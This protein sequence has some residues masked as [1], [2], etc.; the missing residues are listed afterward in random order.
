MFLFF[1]FGMFHGLLEGLEIGSNIKKVYES[2]LCTGCGTCMSICPKSAVEI[3]KDDYEGTYIPQVKTETCD[4]CGLC[5]RVC[6][7]Y[8]VDFRELNLKMFGKQP[9]NILIG[10]YIAC[11]IGHATD[12]EMRYNSASGGL[13]T[14][15]LIFALE[16]GIIDGALVTRMSQHKP[17]E[18]EV[19]I[20]RSKEEI[21]SASGSKYCPVPVNIGLKKILNEK[22]KFAIVGLP[23]HMHGVRKLEMINK[24][25]QD[26]IALHLGLFCSNSVTFLGTEYF[27]QKW[28]VKKE[29]VKKLDY[30]GKGWPGKIV[31]LFQDGKEKIIPR[32][33]TEKSF[34]RRIL[35]SSSFHFDFM[36]QRCLLCCDHT[37]ELSDISFGDPWLPELLKE[38]KI[39]KSLIISRSKNGEELLEKALTRGKIEL[40]KISG[41]KL[42]QAQN[43][44][45]KRTFN[46]RLLALKSLG[47]PTPH[48]ITSK[49]LESKR[50]DR[51]GIL[52]Y[53]PS[54]FSSKRC[55]WRFLYANAVI[56]YFL[57]IVF[58]TLRSRLNK[59]YKQ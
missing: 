18:P 10:N 3:I 48:Y 38:E 20:A 54:Y 12:Y 57:Y 22:G 25:L 46:S 41:N 1:S 17:L 55:L 2:G 16:E 37:C 8:S 14:A 40:V 47:K 34:L 44:S 43:W 53:L 33:T 15:L 51:I 4:Q 35:F 6:P 42:L 13:L 7:G 19:F 27:L 23:C 9:E 49:L 31:V 45:F 11:Y 5:L 56:R 59:R 24:K 21:I 30:R 50:I 52:F 39:G 58:I 28:H 26:K 36:P 29:E 32:G